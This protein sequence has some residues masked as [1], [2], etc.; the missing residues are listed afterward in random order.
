MKKYTLRHKLISF[1]RDIDIKGVRIIAYY[2]PKL[3]IPKP[4]K[5]LLIETLYG[6]N[7]YIDPV[8]DNG[9]EKSIYYTGTY[10]KGTL[11]IIQSMLQ[12]G[13]VFVDV[14]A[15]IGLMSILAA[16]SVG[17]TGKVISFEPNPKTRDVLE[18][19]IAVNTISN[20]QVSKFAIGNKIEETKIY[21]RWDSN[22]GSASLIKPDYETD[23]Y[24]INTIT[25]NDFFKTNK[26]KIRMI[27]LDIEGYELEALKGAKE[28]LETQTPMLIVEC[29]N[30]RENYEQ[31][32]NLMIYSFLKSINKYRFYK[33]SG[34]KEKKSKLQE[35]YSEKDIPAHDNIFCF[36]ENDFKQI[37]SLLLL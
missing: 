35:I 10:E 24:T 26:T 22:R 23:S 30:M 33:L 1:L 14:G 20:I 32:S 11:D 17:D 6:F 4:T 21:D 37:P 3:I 25:L 9:V 27:K 28:I 34:S 29:S 18:Q 7:I 8:I 31:S 36:S 5:A 16:K 13:D 19:N 12:K 15:N 2:L